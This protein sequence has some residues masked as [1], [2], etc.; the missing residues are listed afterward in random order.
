MRRQIKIITSPA[1]FQYEIYFSELKINN[2]L[3]ARPP[4]PPPECVYYCMRK[5]YIRI[6]VKAHSH[7][8]Y[9]SVNGRPTPLATNKYVIQ[10]WTAPQRRCQ[11]LRLVLLL[12]SHGKAKI[13]F[14]F[15]FFTTSSDIPNVPYTTIARSV[16]FVWTLLLPIPVTS[17]NILPAPPPTLPQC[18]K[19][20][21]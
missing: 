18:L 11:S 13:W 3:D 12:Y 7:T 15:F 2:I 17:Y 8:H 21:L 9:I 1:Q 16:F 20:M 5:T 4:Q 19:N 10:C 6:W 14:Y